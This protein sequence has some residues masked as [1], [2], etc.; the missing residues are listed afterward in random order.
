MLGIFMQGDKW[1][2]IVKR[3][4]LKLGLGLTLIVFKP[5]LGYPTRLLN[6]Y[7]NVQLNYIMPNRWKYTHFF[8]YSLTWTKTENVWI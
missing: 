3:K 5:K 7:K 4:D 8:K 2:L 1:F 6:I